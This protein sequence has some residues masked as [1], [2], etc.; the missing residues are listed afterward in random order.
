MSWITS[1]RGPGGGVFIENSPVGES[2]ADGSA[3]IAIK[4]VQNQVRK[5]KDQPEAHVQYSIRMDNI[6]WPW[7][8]QC[9]G[10]VIYTQKHCVLIS[11]LLVSL[12]ARIPAYLHAHIFGEIILFKPAKTVI[13][14]TQ[15]ARNKAF[16]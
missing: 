4:E 8:I 11:E 15:D 7:L 9:A 2:E 10:Q 1:Q 3:E 16:G 5:L 12:F 14:P 6:R 13:V